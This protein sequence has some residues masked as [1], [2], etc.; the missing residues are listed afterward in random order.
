MSPRAP[1]PRPATGR[2]IVTLQ[3]LRAIAALGVVAVHAGDRAGPALPD[4]VRGWIALGHAGVDLFFV[5]SGFLMWSILAQ[6]RQ[7]VSGFLLRR[8]VR[9]VPLYWI[10]TLGWVV[11]ATGAGMGWITVNGEHVLQSLA[12]IPHESPSFPGR[13]WPVLV[14][15]WTLNFEMFFYAVCA[16]TLALTLALTGPGRLIILSLALLGLV[17]LGLAM[18]P[19][20]AWAA[21]YT[22][23][24]LLEFL[25]GC[26]L[27]E[28]WRRGCGGPATGAGLVLCG[29]F[30]LAVAGP[31]T[32]PAG[33]VSRVAGFGVPAAMI[34]FAAVAWDGHLPNLPGLAALGDASYAIYLFHL[35]ALVPVTEL[36]SRLGA[37][38][39][40][41]GSLGFVVVSL[42][43]CSAL[44]VIV[45]RCIDLPL[46]RAF[47][48]RLQQGGGA[49]PLASR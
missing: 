7:T 20:A 35:F 3:Y 17:G 32:D 43:I 27:A 37:L 39:T 34:V 25:A 23:P 21:T 48:A 15:G 29:I 36:W 16:L 12:F 19:V 11:L 44:G 22:S 24:L 38:Q 42:V 45:H 8:A 40:P 1:A 30:W 28:L 18:R 46:Q 47:R 41:A 31:M 14:P 33:H 10:A 2:H 4:S 49:L 6:T 5:L 26:F 9:V 13:N